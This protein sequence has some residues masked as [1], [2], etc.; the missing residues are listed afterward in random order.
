[1]YKWSLLCLLCLALAVW[2]LVYSCVGA[3]A[4]FL[5]SDLQF[6]STQVGF[7]VSAVAIGYAIMMVPAGI[8]ADLMGVKILLSLGVLFLG[9]LIFTVTQYSSFV[10]EFIL[11]GLIGFAG[12]LTMPT[13]SKAV[14]DW[15]D[16]EG[17]ATA[18]G[19]K[20]SGINVGGMMAGILL[21]LLAVRFN[22]RFS[23]RL[24]ALLCIISAIVIFLLYKDHPSQKGQ[25]I[26]SR[27]VTAKDFMNLLADRRFLLL[28][29]TSFLMLLVQFGFTTYLVLFLTR[30]QNF[31]AIAAGKYLFASFGAGILG[32][33]G[34]G[35]LSDFLFQ[36]RRSAVLLFMAITMSMVCLFMGALPQ[37]RLAHW[38]IFILVLAFG[39]TGMGWNGMFLT[40]VVEFTRKELSGSA[41]GFSS[42]IGFIGVI[43]GTPLFGYILDKKESFFLA[44]NFLT[45][46]ALSAVICILSLRKRER[47]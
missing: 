6:T 40:I 9:V 20:Q 17:R 43:I 3:L 16:K 26:G 35:L 41:A 29:A 42:T 24:T 1:M 2:G 12:G 25:Q 18:M 23:L 32:R 4:P 31:D 10:H 30:Q 46:C 19:I 11:F 21:P 44:W 27:S 13:S 38:V 7:L 33:I 37:Y 22:W 28:S 36:D 14:M 39:L 45:I 34:F 15:F 47:N 5:M 8:W